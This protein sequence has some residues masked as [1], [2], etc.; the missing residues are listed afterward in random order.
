MCNS[1]KSDKLPVPSFLKVMLLKVISL[2]SVTAPLTF[3]TV[4]LPNSTKSEDWL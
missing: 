1:D 2:V 3:A 4:N